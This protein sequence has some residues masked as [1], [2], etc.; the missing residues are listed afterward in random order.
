MDDLVKNYDLSRN[1]KLLD[2]GGYGTTA[3]EILKRYDHLDITI[4]DFFG[5][6]TRDFVIEKNHL[7][8][9]ITNITGNFFTQGFPTGFDAILFSHV[10]EIYKPKT[11]PDLVKKVFE[12]LEPD[13]KAMIYGFLS[14]SN[15]DE[16]D[17][18][19]GAR[20]ALYLNVLAA[21]SGMAYP[22]SMYEQCMRDARLTDLHTV[23]GLS[24]EHGLT[25]GYKQA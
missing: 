24:F 9:R 23:S 16:T 18:V 14:N 20:L 13:S 12:A 15:E 6:S 7:D 2:G 22:A 10:L 4:F 21:G 1:K 25:I 5:I 3:S 19:Y 8:T 17:G 11:V